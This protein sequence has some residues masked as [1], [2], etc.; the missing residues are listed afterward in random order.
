METQ[1][2]EDPKKGQTKVRVRAC[3]VAFGDIMRRRGLLTGPGPLTPGYDMVGEVLSGDLPAGTRV[4]A[5]LA[6]PGQGGYAEEIVF[7][8]E[9][10]L[11]VP[12]AVDDVTAAALGL[13]YITALQLLTR[14]CDVEE[15]DAILVHGASGGVGTALLELAKQRGLKTYGTASKANHEVVIERGGIPIDYRTEDFEAVLAEVEPDGVAAVF[16]S[17][18]GDNLRRSARVLKP[19]GTLVTFGVTGFSDGWLDIVR[20]QLP[21]VCLKLNPMA[22]K[23]RMYAITV[24]PG[25]GW[26]ACRDDWSALLE[27]SAQGALHPL[28]GATVP[29]EDA[30]RAHR[31]LEEREVAGKIVL[32]V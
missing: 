30:A 1:E 32:T 5:M 26:R 11:T 14:L 19:S 6:N 8:T 21:Y 18:G 4:A 10:L 20:G 16:D 17:I 29:L 23:V 2:V 7:E 15:G 13:N 12:D 22:P 27:L 9:R 25:C 31:M 3:G 28:V 24:T